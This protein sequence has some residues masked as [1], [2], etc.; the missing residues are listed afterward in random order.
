MVFVKWG[1]VMGVYIPKKR[2]EWGNRFG[3]DKFS[4]V[5]DV[6]ILEGNLAIIWIGSYH[7]K[8]NQ[9]RFERLSPLGHR[10][11][12]MVDAEVHMGRQHV[13]RSLSYARVVK[14]RFGGRNMSNI[15]KQQSRAVN[16]KPH[17]EWRGS[18]FNVLVE[19]MK[20]L[21]GSYVGQAHNLECTLIIQDKLQRAGVFTIK[22]IP[23]GGNLILLLP[24]GD[25]NFENHFL[26]GD[27]SYVRL[28]SDVR[29]LS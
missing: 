20:W 4:K 26:Q 13:D 8:V 29:W 18:T 2:D 27:G 24:E 5:K 14:D 25:E 28:G 12:K 19:E 16:G 1:T 7:L 9:P 22:A 10:K 15:P 21:Y 6:R 23:L 11:M 3:F 17:N